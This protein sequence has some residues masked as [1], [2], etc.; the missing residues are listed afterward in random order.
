[1][2]RTRASLSKKK[3]E[4]TA[5]AAVRAKQCSTPKNI[6]RLRR[7]LPKQTEKKNYRERNAKSVQ[8]PPSLRRPLMRK[9][10][11]N[12]NALGRDAAVVVL[13]LHVLRKRGELRLKGE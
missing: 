3:R 10:S 1:M 8:P 2:G 5:T 11:I 7:Y 12:Q 4:K 6:S 9:D 13:C